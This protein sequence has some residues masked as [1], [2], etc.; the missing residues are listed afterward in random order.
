MIKGWLGLWSLGL[1]GLV[2]LMKLIDLMKLVDL[3]T[4]FRKTKKR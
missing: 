2:D 1:M 3:I 4:P